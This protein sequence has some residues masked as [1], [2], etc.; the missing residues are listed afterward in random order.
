MCV[1]GPGLRAR[2]VSRADSRPSAGWWR[3][4]RLV[5]TTPRSTSA[6]AIATSCTTESAI[7]QTRSYLDLSSLGPW[8]GRFA[9]AVRN[10]VTFLHK[11]GRAIQIRVMLG[12]STT[13]FSELWLHQARP[14]N[15]EVQRRARVTRRHREGRRD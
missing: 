14:R 4:R 2:P 12:E 7:V 1:A 6:S 9:A 11:S 15:K 8:D 13:K 10:A 5:P 3:P